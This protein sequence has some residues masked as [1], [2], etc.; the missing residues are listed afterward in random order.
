MKILVKS[1]LTLNQIKLK[2]IEYLKE[3][4]AEEEYQN[5]FG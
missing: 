3:I 1:Y 5:T 2:N 4:I